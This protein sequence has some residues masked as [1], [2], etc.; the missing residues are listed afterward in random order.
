[1]KAVLRGS[2]ISLKKWGEN[3]ECGYAEGYV[4][5]SLHPP[6]ALVELTHTFTTGG[7]DT[8][9]VTKPIFNILVCNPQPSCTPSL[10]RLI[11]SEL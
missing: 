10:T 4:G 7:L 3:K 1:M 6:R 8:Q 5:T 9:T 11:L 2:K